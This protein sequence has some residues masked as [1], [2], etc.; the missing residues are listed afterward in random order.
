MPRTVLLALAV[1]LALPAVAQAQNLVVHSSLPLQGASAS[2]TRA[3]VRG[4]DLALERA[5]GT[6]GGRRVV[7]RSH[8]DS[9][10]RARTWTPEAVSVNAR[11]AAQDRNAIAYIGEFNSGATAISLPILNEAG[12]LQVSPSNTAVGLTLGGLGADR[13]EPEKYYP[14]GSRHYG[15]V[16]PNDRVQARA[17]GTLIH[18]SGVR[19]LLVV[20][21]REIYGRGLALL[22]ARAARARGIRVVRVRGLTRRAANAGSIAAEVR[23]RR[24][25]GVFYGGI[26][27]NGAV[28]LWRALGRNRRLRLFAGD[29]VAESGFTRRIPRGAARRTRILLSTLH[30][31][32]YPA[33]GQEVFDALGGA[34]PYALYGYEAMSVVLDAINRG[35]A[36]RAGAISGFFA[37]R[38]RDSV[39][40]RYSIDANGDTTLTQYGVYRVAGGVLAFRRVVDAA[41][42]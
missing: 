11:R 30:R 25:D 2:Q 20:H 26:T 1:A 17:A 4:I 13:G 21:D 29:G 15:R 23:R 10:A 28:R 36:T 19:R 16:I 7:H 3:V 38:D 39:L 35:G 12:I 34:D 41:A 8:D 14:A 5:G 40:G 24:A 27:A 6:A 22:A 9:T 31:D 33:S 32:A 37:T 42:P 18:D